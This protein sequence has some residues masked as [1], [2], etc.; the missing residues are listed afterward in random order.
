MALHACLF[1]DE[2]N[3][4]LARSST[5]SRDPTL[6]KKTKHKIQLPLMDSKEILK[7]SAET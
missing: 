3:F 5:H 4:S 6:A 2:S 1:L 7:G